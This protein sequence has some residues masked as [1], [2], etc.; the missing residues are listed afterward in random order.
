MKQNKR[1]DLRDA[2]RVASVPRSKKARRHDDD[3]P[4]RARTRPFPAGRTPRPSP[5][6][7]F[8]STL[9]ITSEYFRTMKKQTNIPT[10]TVLP[11]GLIR[12]AANVR[13]DNP[14]PS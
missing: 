3:A 9:I 11:P 7:S 5:R 13:I 4:P 10:L 6:P 2:P 8:S 1:E 12:N 14:T